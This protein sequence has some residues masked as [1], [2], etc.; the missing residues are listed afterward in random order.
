MKV[1]VGQVR[2]FRLLVAIMKSLVF[3]ICLHR[4]SLKQ[5]AL[6]YVL[7]NLV[8]RIRYAKMCAFF[9]KDKIRFVL[10]KEMNFALF[11]K[12]CDVFLNL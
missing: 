5:K 1:H 4:S 6:K 9:L 10:L 2:R 3:I 11:A 7:K 8:Q 12:I